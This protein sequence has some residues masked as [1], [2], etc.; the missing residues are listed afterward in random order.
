MGVLMTA[1]PDNKLTLE[2]VKGKGGVALVFNPKTWKAF[3]HARLP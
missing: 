2:W 3:V 1:E